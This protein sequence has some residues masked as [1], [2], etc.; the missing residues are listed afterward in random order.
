M[1]WLIVYFVGLVLSYIIILHENKDCS[2]IKL[3]DVFTILGLSLLSWVALIIIAVI[4]I[5][6][7]WD[8]VVI[9]KKKSKNEP[10]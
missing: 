6:E 5:F 3:C 1:I 7:K 2:D 8:A 10:K 9:K 4:Y